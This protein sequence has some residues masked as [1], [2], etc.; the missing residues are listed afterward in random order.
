MIKRAFLTLGFVVL[1]AGCATQRIVPTKTAETPPLKVALYAGRGASGI[2]AVEWCRIVHDSPQMTLTLVDGATVRAGALEGQD[3]FIMPGGSSR[4]EF[5]ALGTNG[6]NKMKDF[7]RKGGA[8]LGTCAGCCLIMDGDNRAR[9]MPW[10]S[11]GSESATFYPYVSVNEKGAKALGIAKGRHK[12]RYHGGPF[13]WPTTN[14][15]EGASFELWGTLD[16]EMTY[17]GRIDHKKKMYGS[18]LILGGT[19]GKG[20]VFVT[21]LH[22]EYYASTHYLVTSAIRWLTGRTVEIPRPQRC[23][24]D[25][26]LGYIVQG[27]RTVKDAETA[28]RVA[29]LEGVRFQPIN[30]DDIWV[31]RLAYLDVLVMPQGVTDKAGKQMYQAINTFIACG[32]R[33]FTLAPKATP[34]GAI[35]CASTDELIRAIE[36]FRDDSK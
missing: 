19:Y 2:G 18:G 8:Y 11:T 34:A 26:A 1:V 31:E 33:L 5:A 16:S 7:I 30:K 36:E 20:R 23:P 10:N 3:L 29:D 32:G 17:R 25:L 22:P 14:Q 28:L 21:S 35:A 27:F 24:G 13:L 6:V 15:I 4:A 9:L 12:V